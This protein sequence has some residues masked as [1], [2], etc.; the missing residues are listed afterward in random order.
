M[1]LDFLTVLKPCGEA[2]GGNQ[3]DFG[4]LI[5]K[6]GCGLIAACD[7]ALFLRNVRRISE[8]EY[9]GFVL[10]KARYLSA[11][12]IFGVSAGKTVQILNDTVS[13]CS[14]RFIPKRRLTENG[15]IKLFEESISKGIPVIVRI[16]ENRKR[17]PYR[18]GST[19]GKMR[20][21]YI[22]VTG[23]NGGKLTFCSWGKRGEMLCSDLYR[24]FGFTGGVIAGK[25]KNEN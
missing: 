15:L 22:I 23:I 9:V 24:F 16:G 4:G 11:A 2:K 5:K 14:F 18:M 6:C 19:E 12:D 1:E 21:H 20:W 8:K 10:E 13:G 25:K 3:S 17:L 7:T